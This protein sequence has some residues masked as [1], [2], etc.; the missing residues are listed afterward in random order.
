[1][2]D[3]SANPGLVLFVPGIDGNGKLTFQYLATSLAKNLDDQ[4]LAD[5]EVA[6]YSDPR[7][8]KSSNRV[9]L[10]DS[11]AL[12]IDL[13]VKN[14]TDTV[15]ATFT[16]HGFPPDTAV[17]LV[18]YSFGSVLAANA[19]QQLKETGVN[20]S[21]CIIDAPA[22]HM[23]K[24]YF[25][26]NK[27][28]TAALIEIMHHIVNLSGFDD[29][30]LSFTKCG[31]AKDTFIKKIT[32]LPLVSHDRKCT[33]QIK[34][35]YN[36]ICLDLEVDLDDIEGVKLH[37]YTNIVKRNLLELID[38][39]TLTTSL[40]S[41]SIITTP[42][43]RAKFKCGTDGGWTG[44]A[45]EIIEIPLQAGTHTSILKDKKLVSI[46]TEQIFSHHFNNTIS[47]SPSA[48]HSSPISISSPTQS[49]ENFSNNGSGLEYSPSPPSSLSP[50]TFV[51]TMISPMASSSNSSNSDNGSE[52]E[53]HKT[54][55]NII[56]VT[57]DQNAPLQS[58][59]FFSPPASPKNKTDTKDEAVLTASIN[60]SLHT[61]TLNSPR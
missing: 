23:Y 61:V 7:V 33:N 53:H 31:E 3:R 45:K 42:E 11:T 54:E 8:P 25:A 50:S 28:A 30:R 44:F 35:I 1:M 18:G 60:T 19:A 37:A 2:H 4:N 20:V 10:P 9:E 51:A 17:L 5:V 59:R 47:L 46:L 13:L 32:A 21:L 43:T 49:P 56:T 36:Q 29:A 40:N 58:M 15:S 38:C 16:K 27:D 26:G 39:S 22:P 57:I 41:L 24:E 55:K 12:Y 52:K 6:T 34:E 14:I 48:P